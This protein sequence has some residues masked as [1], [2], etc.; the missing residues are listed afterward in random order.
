MAVIRKTKADLKV[1]G[2]GASASLVQ[3]DDGRYVI[4]RKRQNGEVE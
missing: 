2:E 4:V 3:P 1:N